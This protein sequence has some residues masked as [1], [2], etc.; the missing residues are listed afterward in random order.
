MEDYAEKLDEAGIARLSRL[1]Y[2]SQRME[3][4]INDLLYFSRLGHPEPETQL[5]DLNLVIEGI[6]MMN[7]TMLQES[8]AAIVLP[9]ALPIIRCN[10]IRMTE[11]FRNLIANAVKYNDNTVKRIEVGYHDETRKYDSTVG[12]VFYVKDD[13]I[14]I[15][16]EFHEEIF[17]IF[18]RLN[19]EDD[20]KKG[21][22]VGLTFVRRIVERDGGRIWLA[23]R[24]G[25]GSTFYF[26]MD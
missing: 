12:R 17:R 9:R 18:K 7:E 16:E 11:V 23:S 5:T 3:Q 15:A 22:G 10:K 4:L 2:L 25:E 21:T 26:T 14:G 20:D 19:T 24:P 1:G 6:Q 8:N 13:G